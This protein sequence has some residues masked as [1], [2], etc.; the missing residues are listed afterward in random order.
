MLVLAA[1]LAAYGGYGFSLPK[2]NTI[3]F[4]DSFYYMGFLWAIF[5]LISA[6]VLWPAPRLTADAVLTT[7]TAPEWAVASSRPGQFVTRGEQVALSGD[8]DSTCVSP[9]WNRPVPCAVGTTPSSAPATAFWLSPETT[10]TEALA[11]PGGA[12]RPRR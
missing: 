1:L 3:Q 11:S 4:A 9:R 2:K 7:F 5:A 8:P 6:F 12:T 10:A